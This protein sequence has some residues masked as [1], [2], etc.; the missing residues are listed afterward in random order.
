LQYLHNKKIMHRDLK[1]SNLLVN[2]LAPHEICNI[3]LC[4]FGIARTVDTNMTLA[5][6]TTL[7]MAPEV[8][9]KLPYLFTADVWSFGIILGEIATREEP[10]ARLSFFDALAQ[11]SK[12]ALPDLPA[13]TPEAFCELRRLCTKVNPGDRPTAAQLCDMIA[14]ASSSAP[15]LSM[16]PVESS[17]RPPSLGDASA[18][19]HRVVSGEEIKNLFL[20]LESGTWAEK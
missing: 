6:G 20:A 4:D 11:L 2:S 14:K 7:W 8:F 9:S 13:G 5:Q 15:E 17:A 10:F 19:G 1:S 12:G 18:E 16:P 3:K